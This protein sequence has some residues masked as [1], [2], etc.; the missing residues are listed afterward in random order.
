[1]LKVP[2][3]FEYENGDGD[4]VYESAKRADSAIERVMIRETSNGKFKKKDLT[5][6]GNVGK[7]GLE[8]AY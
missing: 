8:V 7:S 6:E 5:S 2:F 1:M 4:R 3:S